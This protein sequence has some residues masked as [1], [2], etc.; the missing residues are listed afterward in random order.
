M[1]LKN[2]LSKTMNTPEVQKL[3]ASA[4]LLRDVS[5]VEIDRSLANA[6]TAGLLII[7]VDRSAEAKRHGLNVKMVLV[8]LVQERIAN[9]LLSM[10]T[11]HYMGNDEFVVYIDGLEE[12]R[13][14]QCR[15]EEI[16]AIVAEAP[17][18]VSGCG[19]PLNTTVSIGLV[20]YPEDVSNAPDLYQQG[21][22]AAFLAKKNGRN[23]WAW[24]ESIKSTL[25]LNLPDHQLSRLLALGTLL[26]RDV[27][28][29]ASEAFD[30]LLRRYH[31]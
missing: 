15:A 8:G 23:Q 6:Q 19:V 18:L 5:L 31:Q 12:R 10:E 16:G 3:V 11:L 14:L 7:D 2:T 27:D 22:N 9:S 4:F 1:S 29:M 13:E 17:F 30:A 26:G 24:D 20:L 21:L 28:G 25:Q